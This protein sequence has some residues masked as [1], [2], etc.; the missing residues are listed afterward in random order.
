MA[1]VM[2][3]P[4]GPAVPARDGSDTR[5]LHLRSVLLYSLAHGNQQGASAMSERVYKPKAVTPPRPAGK[6][7]ETYYYAGGP[8]GRRI[9]K[10]EY[11]QLLAANAAS[12]SPKAGRARSGHQHILERRPIDRATMRDPTVEETIRAWRQH[13]DWLELKPNTQ[14]NYEVGFSRPSMAQLYHMKLRE[15]EPADIRE[16]AERHI[17]AED[18]RL[19]RGAYNQFVSH[20]SAIYAWGSKH[21]TRP[22]QNPAKQ[23]DRK[24]KVAHRPWEDAHI[25][26]MMNGASEPV[27]RMVKLALHT[28]LRRSDLFSVTWAQYDGRAISVVPIKTKKA[29][30]TGEVITIPVPGLVPDLNAWRAEAVER[31]LAQGRGVDSLAGLRILTG[32]RGEGLVATSIA[33]PFIADRTRLGLPDWLHIHGLRATAA[34]RLA[35]G[36]VTDRDMMAITGHR[37][38]ASLSIYLRHA[39]Q[40]RGA[41]RGAVALAANLPREAGGTG[42]NQAPAPG[43]IHRAQRSG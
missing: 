39:N 14:R 18:G 26:A 36:G 40:K 12:G 33:K 22:P 4:G 8:G 24:A 1:E 20:F 41:E 17:R 2:T 9:T 37:S 7:A 5:N 16:I 6:V 31:L 34:S 28:A 29:F 23:I 42:E 43:L 11:D 3:G 32:V 10:E 30:A 21:M 27:R 19:Q 25:V 35:E 13:S 38:P 15:I